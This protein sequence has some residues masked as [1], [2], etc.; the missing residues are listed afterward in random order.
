MAGL[1]LT[2]TQARADEDPRTVSRFVQELRNHGLHDLAVEYLNGLRGDATL[3]NELK[4]LLD[5]EEG[6]TLIDEAA[7]SSDLV[8]RE[9]LLHEA[10]TKLEGFAKANAQR[11]E[12]RD[13]LVQL[14]KLLVERGYLAM[15]LSEDAPDKAKKEAKVAEARAAFTQAHD[16]YGKAVEQLNAAYKKFPGFIPEGSPL[17][18]QRD[19]LQ[20]T[21]LNAMLQKGVADYELAQTYPEGSAER[22]QYLKTALEQFDSL[23]KSH[24]EQFAGLAA[25]MWQAKCYEEQGDIGAAIGL[26]KQLLQHTDSRL[27]VLQRHVGFFYIVALAKRKQHA[28]AADEATRWLEK[29]SQRDDRRS[30]EGM[31]VL[32]EMAKSIDA[33]MPEIAHADRPKAVRQIIDTLNQVVRFA[34][35]YKKD[36][37]AL[38]KKY[39]PSAGMKAEEIAR[40]TYEDAMGRADEAIAAQEWERA[41]TLLK[42]A[43][44]KADVV[45]EIEKVN[46]ARYNL[47]FC[48]YKNQQYAEADVLAEHFARR[49][50]QAGL[51]SKAADIAVQSLIEAYTTSKDGHRLSDLDR[52]VS[53][54]EYTAETWPDRDEG[55][56]ARLYLGQIYLGRGQYDPAIAAFGAVRRRSGKWVEAQTQLGGA[57]WAKSRALDRQKNT[58][59]AQADAQKAIEILQGALKTRQEAGAGPTEPGLVANV[60][61]LAIVLTETGKPAQALT[62]LDPIVKAQTVRSGSAYARLMEALLTA[63]ITSNQ[64]QQAIT[65]MKALEQVGG[66][67]NLAQLYYRLG[68]LLERELESLRQ[69][70]DTA[71]LTQMQRSYRTFLTTLAASQTGQSYESLDWAGASLL[72]LD[73]YE[74]AERVIRRVLTEFAEKP[75]YLQQPNGRRRLVLARVRLA[76]AL[77]GQGKLD[78]ANALVEELISQN[79]NPRYIE[80]LF[81]KGMLLEAKAQAGKSNWAAAL[82][83]W[84][85]L[86]KNL[87]RI[88]PRPV[89]YYDVW[90]HVAWVLSKQRDALKARQTLQGVMRLTP[91]VGSPEM[92]A[93]YHGLLAQ[94]AKR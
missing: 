74:D 78:E 62:L 58:A 57:H 60:G 31:G 13:A 90:Y 2:M 40:L 35:P 16:V 66:G 42:A 72:T 14:A 54:A 29:Y 86:G 83:Y 36:A 5:Y 68:K 73:A 67:R 89:Q 87:E 84:E 52:L 23:Y 76:A 75:E 53:V 85:N 6:R 69:K 79:Q 88:R 32:L 21:M 27:R 65:S 92:K 1:V 64:V 50:P 24:R 82:G 59:A 63:Y 44:R 30:R 39:K 51:A 94:L 80:P 25:Q 93:K 17:R 61:D 3:P 47:A 12:A 46:L 26:Y 49:Y 41:I 45:R 43:V 19:D 70:G 20:T 8:L 38:L 22:S 34:S 9:Q 28:L 81:E 37:L 56:I 4:V 77:R 11:P 55:D 18:T 15:L 71:A 33:Q 10:R 91:S 7:K 48:Y